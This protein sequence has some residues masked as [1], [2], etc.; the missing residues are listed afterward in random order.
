MSQLD[1]IMHLEDMLR[2]A[3]DII[4]EQAELLHQHDIE[5]EDGKLEAAEQE[6]LKRIEGWC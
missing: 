6:F 2:M 4:H 3:L 1:V 5:T